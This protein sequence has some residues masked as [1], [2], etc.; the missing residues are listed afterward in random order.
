MPRAEWKDASMFPVV[1]PSDGEAVRLTREMRLLYDE[2]IALVHENKRLAAIHDALLPKLL[3]GSIRVP[4][5]YDADDALG[6][7]AEAAGV[8][9]Q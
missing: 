4:A 1:I 9:V 8:A 5:S 6:T 7:I 3:S 2:V